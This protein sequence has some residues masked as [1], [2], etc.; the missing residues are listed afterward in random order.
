[1]EVI[2]LTKENFQAQIDQGITLV[3][4]F[5]LECESCQK[6]LPVDEELAEEIRHQATVVKVDIEQEIELAAEYGVMSTPTLML[7]KD[8]YQVETMIG[9]QSKEKLR[10][11]ILRYAAMG[12]TC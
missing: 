7:F 11:T 12:E 10:Q 4:F 3:D 8:G 9:L 6:Q 5:G 2:S 1:M